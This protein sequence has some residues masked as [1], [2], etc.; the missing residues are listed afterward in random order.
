[1]STNPA[2]PCCCIRPKFV[3]CKT[4]S[5]ALTCPVDQLGEDCDVIPGVPPEATINYLYK[6]VSCVESEEECVCEEI[7]EQEGVAGGFGGGAGGG[8]GGGFGGLPPGHT[9]NT[10]VSAVFHD[11]ECENNQ[12]PG[13][14]E[15]CKNDKEIP[16]CKKA[17]GPCGPMSV[18]AANDCPPVNCQDQD[19]CEPPPPTLCCCYEII[20]GE[21]YTRSCGVCPDPIP[22]NCYQVPACDQCTVDDPDECVL[23]IA[24]ACCQTN[25][26]CKGCCGTE[27]C[28]C[29]CTGLP[30]CC[31]CEGP[32]GCVRLKCVCPCPYDGPPGP[33]LCSGCGPPRSIPG[34]CILS[35][36]DP[37]YL[38]DY[39]YDALI[40]N[41]IDKGYV[42][43]ETGVNLNTLFLFGYGYKNL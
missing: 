20:G 6:V 9:I 18:G 25:V 8:F 40:E 22:D 17:C 36:S 35:S 43:T 19:C 14:R 13:D 28:D 38:G 33:P 37:E 41:R 21:C 42:K 1:M 29:F 32:P 26:E 10:C 7:P 39:S 5:V 31:K 34:G 11:I 27:D 23:M 16:C 2:V 12:P 15:I 30:F 4:Y 3:C 24:A